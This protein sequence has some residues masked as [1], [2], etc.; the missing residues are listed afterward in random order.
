MAVIGKRVAA[1]R[2]LFL[3]ALALGLLVAGLILTSFSAQ[4]KLLREIEQDQRVLSGHERVALWAI[5]GH[6]AELERELLRL[7]RLAD[8]KKA[9]V[10]ED[11]MELLE[12]LRPP[13]NRLGKGALRVSR[14]TFYT[15]AGA[16]YLRAHAPAVYGDHAIG[17]RGLIAEAIR[18]RRVLKGLEAED[19]ILYL[20][21]VA[22]L[23][24]EG[25]FLGVIEMGSSLVPVV[26]TTK[27]LTG[28]EVAVLPGIK[29]LQAAESSDP[30]LFATVAP[31]LR[32]E[33]EVPM[34]IRRVVAVRGKTYAAT[35]LPL[36]DFSG[37]KA[38]ILTILAD[39]SAI[40]E[41]LR[42]SQLITLGISAFG[43]ALAVALLAML[44]RKLDGSYADLEARVEDRT[45]ELTALH[46]TLTV[47]AARLQ[48]LTRLNQLISASLDMDAV[49]AEIAGAAAM[50]MER[51]FVRIWIA[52]E[53]T[54]TL[55]L[56]ASSD[57]QLD[58]D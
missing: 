52:D 4:Q 19:G 46:E 34:P 53:A 37:R 14:I 21:V 57:A 30:A 23:Y 11:R 55:E 29:T 10:T 8:V 50:L 36:K 49:L 18:A 40:T 32:L 44:A 9:V 16:V 6:L 56:R 43:F 2:W 58:R 25:R 27:L 12:Q 17:H 45:R 5:E 54:Q 35:L 28:G 33:E 13:L 1:K 47:R 15:P 22:P 7:A 31:L 41:L 39:S 26:D 48:T 24:H 51:A 42:G 38:G 20:W 3:T